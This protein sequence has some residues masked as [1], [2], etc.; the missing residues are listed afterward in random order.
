MSLGLR[1]RKACLLGTDVD[2][3]GEV[4]GGLSLKLKRGGCLSPQASTRQTWGP[5]STFSVYWLCGLVELVHA[6]AS[7]P[8]L[9]DL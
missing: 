3:A 4:G 9:P 7:V 1:Q 8:Q 5:N 6:S 2:R